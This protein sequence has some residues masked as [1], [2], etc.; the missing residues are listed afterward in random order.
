M[1]DT[2]LNIFARIVKGEVPKDIRELL[3]TG[4]I[5]AQAKD[6]IRVTPTNIPSVMLRRIS[7]SSMGPS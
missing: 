7:L 1:K 2:T 5:M 6:G 3:V 4:Q